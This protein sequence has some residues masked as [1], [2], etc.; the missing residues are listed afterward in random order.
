MNSLVQDKAYIRQYPSGQ[1]L[2]EPGAE[3]ASGAA[4][5]FWSAEL[6]L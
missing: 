3:E 2:V 5:A 6:H 4:M 1:L